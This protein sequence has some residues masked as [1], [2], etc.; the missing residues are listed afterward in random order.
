MLYYRLPLETTYNTRELG[1]LPAK[2][3]KQTKWGTLIRSDDISKVNI[4]DRNWLRDYGVKTIIDLRSF[5]ER[6]M[7]PYVL[8]EDNSFKLY[9]IPLMKSEEVEKASNFKLKDTDLGKAYIDM[10]DGVGDRFGEL[11]EIISN[12]HSGGILFHCSAGKDR[13]GVLAS[14]LLSVLGVEKADIVANYEITYTYL[15]EN[16]LFNN[17]DINNELLQS[18][19][20]WIENTLNHIDD[21]YDGTINYLKSYGITDKIL[22]DFRGKCLV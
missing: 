14:I 11:V 2:G 7:T 16:P 22:E 18:K 10:I 6:E 9:H 5:Q 4:H 1:G 17:I 3:N 21:K 12:R 13:T 20:E 15:R 19:R 8:E